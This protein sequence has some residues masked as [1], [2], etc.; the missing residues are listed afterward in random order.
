MGSALLLE[1]LRRALEPDHFVE[2]ELASGGMGAV[3]LGHDRALGRP[4]A[5]KLLRPELASAS[6]AARFL[7]E[8]RILAGLQHPNVVQVYR[9][10]EADGL[11]FYVMEY[12]GGETLEG[13]LRRGPLP[14]DVALKV[15]R[16]LL[17]GLEAAHGLGVVHRDVKPANLM[18]IRRRAL[19][20]DFGIA[21]ST[22][23]D[24]TPEEGSGVIGTPG[25]MAPEQLRNE[26]AT[27][28]TDVYSAGALLYEA[29]TGRRWHEHAGEWRGIPRGIASVLQR[30]LARAPEDRW[31]DAATFRRALWRMRARRYLHRTLGLVAAAL[32]VGAI[33]ARMVPGFKAGRA[34]RL[35]PLRIVVAPFRAV[36]TDA[37]VGAGDSLAAL[38]R[39]ELAGHPDFS[40]AA[41]T[42]ADPDGPT[43]T[44]TGRLEIEGRALRVRLSGALA[45]GTP[46]SLGAELEL[47]GRTLS[48]AADAV[49]SRVIHSVW[50]VKSP[51]ALSLPLKALPQSDAGLAEFLAAERLVGEARW[52]EAYESYVRAEALDSTCWLCAWRIGDVQRWLGMDRDPVRLGRVLRYVDS[53]PEVYRSLIRAANVPMP[54]RIDTLESAA[55]Q[56]REFFLPH[57]QLGDELFHRGP[58]IGR[59]RH[60]AIA[61]LEYAARLRPDY[62]P[63]WEHL[64]WVRTA[65]GDSIG[66]TEALHWLDRF[67]AARDPFSRDLRALLRV[68][69]AWRFLD[70]AIASAATRLELARPGMMDAPALGA[71]PRLLSSFDAPIGAVAMGRMLL[72]APREDLIRSGGLAAV[73]GSIALGRLSDAVVLGR[74]YQERGLDPAA[75]L[76]M[77]ELAAMVLLFD[78]GSGYSSGALVDLRRLLAPGAGAGRSRERAQWMYRLLRRR[79]GSAAPGP[80]VD[81]LW[82]HLGPPFAELLAADSLARQG[83]QR[84]ALALTDGIAVDPAVAQRDPFLRAATYLLRAE[85]HTAVG[86]E[87]AARRELRWHE[88]TDLLGYPVGEPQAAEV[89]WA[90]GTLA[91]WRRA[92]LLDRIGTRGA[93]LCAVLRGVQRQWRNGDAPFA[94]RADTAG[95]RAGDLGCPVAR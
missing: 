74:E 69:Y 95:R 38:V 39:A 24:G 16:D 9:V 46:A 90:F 28:R 40:V 7:A 57:L 44:V 92:Q 31:T 17:D 43:L 84:E 68:G 22:S 37:W 62:A 48:E 89:D 83:D 55:R 71:G 75:D 61:P 82:G 18:L 60:D 4:V 91:R 27:P 34:A 3:F 93:E 5:I 42:R 15:G 23:D 21:V 85:W 6:A 52:G 26:A 94:A 8:A 53:F 19:L 35:D 33:G 70:P 11:F 73:L 72:A 54:D 63:A 12:L 67:G 14:V 77:A 25:Y 13:R 47:A 80:G 20:T 41:G 64:L 59:I 32:V 86:N 58:L 29:F 66:A 79:D 10:G 56:A 65:E 49:A 51:I 2:M 36:G 50:T 1:R 81:Q 88:N 87:A 76:F 45:D 78:P 30:A